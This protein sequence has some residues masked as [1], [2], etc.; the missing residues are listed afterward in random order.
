ML[1]RKCDSLWKI[2]IF[3]SISEL[4]KVLEHY[5]T[6]F[7]EPGPIHSNNLRDGVSQ[8]G[9]SHARFIGWSEEQLWPVEGGDFGGCEARRRIAGGHSWSSEQWERCVREKWKYKR[10]W[11]V[12]I[13]QL[14]DSVFSY[15]HLLL[16]NII[17][18]HPLETTDTH[19]LIHK[20]PS[21]LSQGYSSF[22]L[23]WRRH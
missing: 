4:G 8:F 21:I 7:F 20:S 23:L 2:T 12:F 18:H 6:S 16:L 14:I 19:E 22:G 5:E 11:E 15:S 13:L 3:W 17:N 9:R 1:S 10:R